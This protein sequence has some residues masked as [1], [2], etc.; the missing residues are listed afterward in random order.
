MMTSYAFVLCVGRFF[1]FFLPTAA[2]SSTPITK[3]Y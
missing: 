1:F 3:K 2:V